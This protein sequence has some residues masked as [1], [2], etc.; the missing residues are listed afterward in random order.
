MAD[1]KCYYTAKKA[2]IIEI[3]VVNSIASMLAVASSKLEEMTAI[4]EH[5]IKPGHPVGKKA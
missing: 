3:A 1:H 4:Q 2:G 5:T